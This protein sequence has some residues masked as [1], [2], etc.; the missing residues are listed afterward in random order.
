MP[1]TV[2]QYIGPDAEPW[3]NKTVVLLQHDPK[4]L[5]KQMCQQHNFVWI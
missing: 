5:T 3:A 4:A 1:K 2:T